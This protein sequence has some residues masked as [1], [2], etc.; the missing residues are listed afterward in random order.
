MR[1]VEI[2]PDMKAVTTPLFGGQ[3]QH[4][5]GLINMGR[6]CYRA[7]RFVMSET[8]GSLASG[9]LGPFHVLTVCVHPQLSLGKL[10]LPSI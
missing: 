3:A 7:R 1:S 9:W 10:S 5:G 2:F 8:E 6:A 4:W